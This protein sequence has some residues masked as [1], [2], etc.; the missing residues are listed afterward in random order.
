MA[1]WDLFL[2]LFDRKLNTDIHWYGTDATGWVFQS[3]QAEEGWVRIASNDKGGKW[4]IKAASLDISH[5]RTEIPIAVVIGR[6]TDTKSSGVSL[7]KWY[8]P[9]KDCVAKN[10]IVAT[11]NMS[12]EY[13]FENDFVFGSGNIASSMAEAICGAAMQRIKEVSGKSL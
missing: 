12:G 13:Q 9:L 3:A 1:H 8:V 5:T 4:D 6:I 2:L 7:Y 10:G 11:T